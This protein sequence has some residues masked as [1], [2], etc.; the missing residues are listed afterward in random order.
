[1]IKISLFI[2]VWTT[3]RCFFCTSFYY[4]NLIE[5]G[6]EQTVI[7]KAVS[8]LG[9]SNRNREQSDEGS[10]LLYLIGIIYLVYT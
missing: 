4:L 2:P 1:M 9:L 5:P 8:I 6:M 10:K 3:V 7:L